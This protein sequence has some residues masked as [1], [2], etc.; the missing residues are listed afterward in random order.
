MD[1]FKLV[2]TAID[3]L[4]PDKDEANKHKLKMRELE[5]AG[6]TRDLEYRFSAILTEAKSKDKFVSRARPAFLW[7]MYSFILFAIPMGVFSFYQPT[8]A[9]MIANG[10]KLYLAAIPGEMW[11]VFGVGFTGYTVAR[12]IDKK[13]QTGLMQKLFGKVNI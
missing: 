9:G 10:M 4:F 12:G 11:A 7:V 5:A 1:V 13:N 2:D 3:K 6:E 8:A